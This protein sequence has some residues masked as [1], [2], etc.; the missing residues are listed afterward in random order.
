MEKSLPGTQFICEMSPGYTS[1]T[2][3]DAF[4]MKQ[5][6]YVHVLRSQG[7]GKHIHTN[8]YS[9]HRFS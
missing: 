3:S 5:R 7:A 4:V 1:S 8:T 2:L 6:R 9:K